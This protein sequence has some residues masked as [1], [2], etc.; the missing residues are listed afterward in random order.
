[1]NQ[2]KTAKREITKYMNG[3]RQLC[4]A[5]DG[6]V[7]DVG[8]VHVGAHQQHGFETVFK[9]IKVQIPGNVSEKK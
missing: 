9:T 2:I 7:H 1:M 5:V 8:P 6:G 4:G 3:R